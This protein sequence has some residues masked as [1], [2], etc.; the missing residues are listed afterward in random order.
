M[1]QHDDDFDDDY[2]PDDNDGPDIDQ[3][4]AAR[5]PLRQQ[6]KRLERE[7]KELKTKVEAGSAAE[8]QIAFLKAGIDPDDAKAKYFVKGY[9]GDLT[10]DAIKAEAVAAGLIEAQADDADVVP[11]DVKAAHQ[12]SANVSAGG[13]STGTHS[14]EQQLAEAQQAGQMQLVIALKQRIA[15]QARAR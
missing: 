12:R 6:L 7:N 13:Q 10:A 8:R 3:A 1:S 11:D 9:D 5:N 2:G 4:P 14:L 15:A